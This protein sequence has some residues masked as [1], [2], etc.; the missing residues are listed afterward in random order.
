MLSYLELRKLALIGTDHD[1]ILE[2]L[3]TN[4]SRL[5]VKYSGLRDKLLSRF[6]PSVNLRNW[7]DFLKGF[8]HKKAPD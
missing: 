1:H 6:E 2:S 3:I 4:Y 8:R 5:T 7:E